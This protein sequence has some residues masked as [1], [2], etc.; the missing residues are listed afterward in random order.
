MSA[1]K[2]KIIF[3]HVFFIFFYISSS[4]NA[5]IKYPHPDETRVVLTKDENT[6]L[7][8]GVLRIR[9]PGDQPWLVQSWVEDNQKRK[10]KIVFPTL[11]RL[12]PDSV[13][14]LT[15]QDKKNKENNKFIVVLFIPNADDNEN[16]IVTIPV[17]YRLKILYNED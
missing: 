3:I 5:D 17:A 2:L 10:S 15:I 4:A 12:E 1:V 8:K 13:I 6:S 9:N 7:L 16:N 11:T 14:N